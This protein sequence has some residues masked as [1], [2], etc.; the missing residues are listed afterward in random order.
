MAYNYGRQYRQPA[1]DIRLK[2]MFSG[3]A[4]ARQP[5]LSGEYYRPV[6]T[7]PVPDNELLRLEAHDSRLKQRI[8]ILKFVSRVVAMIMSATTLAPLVM[9]LVKYLETRN[10]YYTVDGQQRTA[11]ANNSITWYTYM[12]TA[13]AAVSFIL[14]SI[15]LFA[16]WRGVKQANAADKVA[17]YWSNILLVGHIVV[18][19]VSAGIYR[20]G[21]NPVNG[22][23]RDLWGWSCSS[24]A[25]EIQAVITDVNFGK[26]CN[27]QASAVGF[28]VCLVGLADSQAQSV[29]FYSGLVNVGTGLLSASIYLLAVLR[30]RS[31]RKMKKASFRTNE[32][33]EPLRS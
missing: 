4:N 7:H 10:V 24:T 26:F 31:K 16:Y 32:G 22:K 23:F 20:Y 21:K 33:T 30:I 8:R 5:E 17:G 25:D 13:V 27:I 12:Y 11:W 15:I 2:P 29:S 18:W 1:D 19:A 3:A 28:G 14:N 6:A 9:T